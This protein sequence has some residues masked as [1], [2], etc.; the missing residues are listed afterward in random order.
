[1]H[2]IN[3]ASPAALLL[4]YYAVLSPNTCLSR[5]H[6]RGRLPAYRWAIRGI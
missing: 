2:I 5:Q 3:R 6:R 4:Q 1:M